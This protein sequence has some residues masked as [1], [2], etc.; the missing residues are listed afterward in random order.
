MRIRM[1]MGGALLLMAWACTE[2]SPRPAS[3]QPAPVPDAA[4]QPGLGAQLDVVADQ[5]SNELLG[6]RKK[7]VA[8]IPFTD[9]NGNN[10]DFGKLL[11]EE[12]VAR[13][14]RTGR[15]NVM[16]RQM[17]SR[18]LA[19]QKLQASGLFDDDSAIK[20]GR[21][22]GVEALVSGTLS[23]LDP[24]VIIHARVISSE[25]GQIFGVASASVRK[26]DAIRRLLGWNPGSRST[27]GTTEAALVD[28]FSPWMDRDRFD[29]EMKNHWNAGYL[30]NR[31]EGR[32]VNG[33][34]EFRA[35]LKPFPKGPWAFFW[36]FGIPRDQYEKHRSELLAKGFK[37][38][39]L[40]IFNGNDNLPRYQTC[41]F[42]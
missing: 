24:Q 5:I 21:L 41:W 22:L 13:L 4:L 17:L 30:P 40:Q 42:K 11:S 32:D 25:S 35:T 19:E 37:E 39:H 3:A 33:S 26:D 23:D 16:E 14:V 2:P 27:R 7:T 36:W 31:V 8:V 20:L 1:A 38:T 28:A 6:A 34:P 15:F 10:N 18:I 9:L 29:R 12:L